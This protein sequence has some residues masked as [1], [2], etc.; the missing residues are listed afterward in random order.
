MSTFELQA[1]KKTDAPGP[2]RD[3]ARRTAAGPGR[4]WQSLAYHAAPTESAPIQAKLA[5]GPADGPLE[6]EADAV[7]ERLAGGASPARAPSVGAAAAPEVTPSVATRLSGST[8]RG[9]SLPE[10]ER[11]YFEPRLGRPLGDVRVHADSEAA[12]LADALG[13]EAF[14]RGSHVYFAAGRYAPQAAPGRRLLAHE[15][16]HVTQQAGRGAAAGIQRTPADDAKAVAKQAHAALTAATVDKPALFTALGTPGR[17]ATKVAAAK[18]AYK[19]E[20]GNEL[21]VALAAALK[22]DDL[23]HAMFLLNAP[24][25]ATTAHADVTVD[26]AGT[27]AHKA[28]ADGGDVSVHTDVEYTKS[29]GTK[30]TD[31]F[32][33]GYAGAG[34]ADTRVMQFIWS[35]IVATQPDKTETHVDKKGIVTTNGTMDLTVD[36]AKPAYKVDSAK[37]D[38]PYYE[39]GGLSNRTAGGTTTFDRPSEFS[40]LIAK[41]FDAG[42][43]K[44]VERD[45]FDDYVI[46]GYKT[47]YHVSLVVEW[48]YTSKAAS[49]RKTKFISGD[50]PA[51]LPKAVKAALVKDYPKFDYVQ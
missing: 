7:A 36:P 33:I 22:D 28:K 49:T 44:V 37:A 48:I 2:S 24:P 32:S 15:L 17:D 34:S 4:L 38:N 46:K 42:A 19:T 6:L 29:D 40:D 18:A 10:V 5:V 20:Y 45:H 30:R 25:P 35:E 9:A 31:G 50:A 13:A 47:V 11:A 51:A 21:E 41:Q 27:E 39:S 16:A 1:R 43:T 26:K 8:S 12:T 14:T 3:E 23:A